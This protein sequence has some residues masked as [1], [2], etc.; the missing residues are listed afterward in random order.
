MNHLRDGDR[1]LQPSRSRSAES[2]QC[3]ARDIEPGGLPHLRGAFH[4]LELARAK[5]P[6]P[7]FLR[8]SP[9]NVGH[10]FKPDPSICAENLKAESWPRGRHRS[11]IPG[12][13]TF[14]TKEYRC[15]VVTVDLNSLS[16]ALAEHLGDGTTQIDHS[17]YGVNSHR[18]KAAA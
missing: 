13:A 11:E 1:E 9:C 10:T 15:R 2:F 12:H 7:A 14:H 16:K 4:R 6:C 5:Q 17:V 3:H 18:G 8:R